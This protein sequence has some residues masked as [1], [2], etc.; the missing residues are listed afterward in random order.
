M[1]N[2]LQLFVKSKNQ[3]V[4]LEAAS[5]KQRNIVIRISMQKDKVIVLV[6]QAKQ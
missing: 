6:S 5:L 4:E 1:P 2:I 3:K